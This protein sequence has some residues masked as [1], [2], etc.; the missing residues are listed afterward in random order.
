M[1]LAK[2]HQD[3]KVKNYII[4]GLLL[5]F[6]IMV[7]AVTIIKM[8]SAFRDVVAEKKLESQKSEQSESK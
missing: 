7:F 3:R 6:V 4:L 5:L 2:T 8:T 1:P